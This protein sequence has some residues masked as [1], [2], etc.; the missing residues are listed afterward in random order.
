VLVAEEENHWRWEGGYMGRGYHD[1]VRLAHNWFYVEGY[2][3][4]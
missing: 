3:P 4:T 2:H 1:V